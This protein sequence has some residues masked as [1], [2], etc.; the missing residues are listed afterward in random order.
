[1]FTEKRR[2]QIRPKKNQSRDAEDPVVDIQ[3]DYTH[4]TGR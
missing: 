4:K 3:M 1:M 2:H